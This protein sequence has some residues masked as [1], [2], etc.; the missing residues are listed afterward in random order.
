MPST[1]DTSF[2]PRISLGT[3]GLKQSGGFIHEEFLTRLRGKN[4]IRTYNEMVHNSPV[5]AA[6]IGIIELLVRQVEWHVEPADESDEAKAQAEDTEAALE[7]M[8]H[9][10]EDFLS[11]VLSMLWAGYSIFEVV[12]KI[13]RGP[14]SSDLQTRS[15]LSDGKWAW[16]KLEIRSQDT[17]DRWV[18]EPETGELAGFVQVDSYGTGT[19]RG[20][21]FI[22]MSKS[23]LFRTKSFKG[24]PEGRSLLRPAVIPYWYIKR[25]QEF[26]AIGIERNLAGMPVMEVPL[27]I[28]LT[29]ATPADRALRTELE[30]FVTQIKIDERWGG[31]VP[32]S[33]DEEGKPTGFNLKLMNS[34]GRKLLDSD[35][36][37]KRHR[38]E[39][40]MIFLEQFLVMGT[41]EAGGSRAVSNDMTRLFGKALTSIMDSIA[42]ILNLN[43]I[44]QRQRLNGVSQE[45]D[46]YIT[47]SDVEGPKLA[48]MGAYLQ[49]LA[50]SGILTPNPALERRALEIGDLPQPPLDEETA[51]IPALNEDRIDQ[52]GRATMSSE[53]VKV[54]LMLNADVKKGKLD[55]NVA[56]NLLMN[57]LGMDE[58]RASLLL[59]PE[60]QEEPETLD[61]PEGPKPP[62]V[63]G[64][65]EESVEEGASPEGDEEVEEEEEEGAPEGDEK[66]EEEEEKQR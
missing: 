30:K 51:H 44:P 16:R 57:T 4:A 41:G 15:K 6:A 33:L 12:Y 9:T 61:G 19:Y 2:K 25:I 50:A 24:N 31:L 39:M 7:D 3:T 55:R 20:P 37:V 22:P 53:H 46:P 63:P 34:S 1:I 54:V 49:A 48:E 13:R 58:E 14:D 23:L 43:L 5:L 29:D 21:V 38:A 10:F 62:S 59:P 45:F 27:R 11:E 18:F 60:E 28:L 42:A 36:I 17:V 65:E 64:S 35:V 32:A 26:E 66:V 56:L 52:V 40:L 47:H 8:E